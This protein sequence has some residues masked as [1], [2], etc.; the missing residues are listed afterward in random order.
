MLDTL[1]KSVG[2]WVVKALIALLVVSFAVWGI[3]DV[4][5]GYRGA[6]LARVGDTE[7]SNQGYQRVQQQELRTLSSAN[8]VAHDREPSHPPLAHDAR[9]LLDVLVR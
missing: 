4:F 2:S 5:T 6:S 1:R 3:G 8:S 7:I 9:G